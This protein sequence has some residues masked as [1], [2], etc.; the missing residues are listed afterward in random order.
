MRRSGWLQVLLILTIIITGTLSNIA[1]GADKTAVEDKAPETVKLGYCE[2]FEYGSFCQVLLDIGRQLAEEGSISEEFVEKYKDTD[3]EIKFEAGDTLKLWNDMCDNNVPGA[4]YQISR[5]AFFDLS[6]M[7]ES[8][9]PEMVNRDDVDIMFSMGTAT[10]VYLAEHEETDK[11]MNM[12]SSDPIASGIVKSETER[13]NKNAFATIDKTPYI[14]QLDTGYKFLKFKKLGV[15]YEDNEEAYLYSAIDVVEQKAKEYGF[16][17]LYE[18]VDEPRD[19]DDY[20]RYYDELKEA[21]RKLT[22]RGIDCLYVTIGM[23]DYESKMHELLDDAIIPANIM[24][25]AQD[26]FLPL[27]YGVMFGVTINDC[28]ETAAHVVAQMRAYA[29]DGVPFDE[30]DMICETTPKIGLNLSTAQEIGFS[31]T[32]EDLQ[33]IDKIFREDE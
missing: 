16:E 27:P 32:F 26:D 2:N 7:D 10:G 25:L 3:Y 31:A 9:Y 13:Y 5:D 14:R 15:V 11:F 20:D 6:E 21:Y 23:I 18:Y 28:E 12:Y 22:E 30:L 17:V 1:Y 33:I 24:T 29:E 4:R 8:E 19:D